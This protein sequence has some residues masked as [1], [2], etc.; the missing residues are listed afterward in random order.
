MNIVLNIN[1]IDIKNIFYSTPSK[2]KIIE[3]IFTKIIYHS[4]YLT[5]NGIYINC[6]MVIN[7]EKDNSIYFDFNLNS[8][9]IYK[10]YKL[11]NDLINNYKKEKKIQ[12][13]NKLVLYEQL[14][15]GKLK[16]FSNVITP[17]KSIILKISGIWE[18][19]K[20]NEIGIAYRLYNGFY[21][22]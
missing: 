9:I 5:L 4:K 3:G 20:T 6:V 16:I 21:E 2:N 1:Q 12:Y 19:E 13:T 11:E 15:S 8:D 17:K 22:S 10:I 18:N 14:S 7:E